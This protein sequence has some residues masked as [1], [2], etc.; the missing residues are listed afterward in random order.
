MR[1]LLIISFY[2]L[3]F[4]VPLAVCHGFGA[5]LFI[6]ASDILLV[7]FLAAFFAHLKGWFWRTPRAL[8]AFLFFAGLSMYFAWSPGLAVYN[9]V[10][11]VLL[12]TAAMATAKV[13]KTGLIKETGIFAALGASAALQA[14]IGF[15]QFWKQSSIGLGLL[16]EPPLGQAIP[17]VAK[18]VINGGT[19][20]RAYGTFP[21]P[22]V[23]AGFLLLGLCALYCLWLRRPSE[24]ELFSGWNTLAS[25]AAIG[26]GIFTVIF[27]LLISF[28]RTGWAIA[29]LV[30]LAAILRGVVSGRSFRQAVR[31]S[32]LLVAAFYLLYSAFLPYVSA[33]A[34]ISSSEP[35]VTLRT[36]Y[37]RIGLDI[38]EHNL[39]GV[40]IGNQV[41]YA[42]QSGEYQK[43]GLTEP[44]QFQPIHNIYIL[45]PS[46]I[47]VLGALTFL[48][49]VGRL[50]I[51][52]SKFQILNL[53][54]FSAKLMLGALLLFGLTDHFLWTAVSGQLML[55]L[56]IGLAMGLNSA[57]TRS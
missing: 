56:T 13:I 46:E 49:F 11:L 3:I 29:I 43:F 12:A 23:L 16:G 32:I 34:Q 35:A 51:P 45:I 33:R 53:E 21:H 57:S 17:G 14:I 15:L 20:I 19:L 4:S 42:E 47:G 24:Y 2:A 39:L 27:G 10:R 28:S 55:W 40:G 48:F 1:R 9:F 37:N 7:M 52:N 44:W 36:A 22:N 50:L 8:I 41:L 18:V 31:L 54:S 5:S 38:I 30:T 25:D 26:L 6:Y